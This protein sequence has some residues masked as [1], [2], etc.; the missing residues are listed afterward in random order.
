MNPDQ[1]ENALDDFRKWFAEWNDLEETDFPEPT[2]DFA[3]LV[4][5]FAAMRHEVN[6]QTKSARAALEQSAEMLKLLQEKPAP[7]PV[8]DDSA[9]ETARPFIKVIVDVYDQLSLA[10]QGVEKRRDSSASTPSAP[11][12]VER[13]GLW[14]KLFG[15]KSVPESAMPSA[16]GEDPIKATLD[17]LMTGYKMSMSRI[18]RLLTQHGLEI[19]PALDQPFDP[20][21]MEAIEVDAKSDKPSGTVVAEIR[22]GY[23]WNGKIF[24]FAQVKVAR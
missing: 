15:A 16:N 18:D 17:A 23:R 4:S 19:I 2:V 5:G 10:S 20:E 1:L 12:P 21:V 22:R 6:L 11:A 13:S 8:K 7:T 14:G 3:A 9:S 24:R